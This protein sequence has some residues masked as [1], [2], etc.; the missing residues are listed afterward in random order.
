MASAVPMS[1]SRGSLSG[2]ALILLGAWGGL[3][4]FIGPYF[5][6]GFSP[7]KAWA[8]ST[9]RL[10]LSILPGVVVLLTGLVVLTTRS[11]WFGGLCALIAALGGA[12]F[13]LGQFTLTVVAGNAQTYSPGSPIGDSLAR[14]T[15]S[16]V[17]SFAGVG[18][19]IVF[20]A[21]LA[22]GR[23]SIAAHKDHVK[24]GDQG[25][26]GQSFG[27]QGGAG[28]GAGPLSW[29]A[30]GWPASGS[31]LTIRSSTRTRLRPRP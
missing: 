2:L 19:L 11:R 20:F 4:P 23:Q 17:G 15:M 27:S 10:Y 30:A 8:Y 26:G 3:A 18:V 7:D 5:Q 9:G 22:L 25:P 24:F 6:F 21:A 1:R 29:P 16:E 13:A 12:W 31:R 28:V 14:I